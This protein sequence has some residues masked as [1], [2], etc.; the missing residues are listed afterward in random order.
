MRNVVSAVGATL[1]DMG[2]KQVAPAPERRA[3]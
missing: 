3:A 1:E 2:I